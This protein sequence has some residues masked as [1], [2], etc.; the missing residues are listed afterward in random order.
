MT[1]AVEDATAMGISLAQ[2]SLLVGSHPGAAT[3]GSNGR[4]WLD[5]V[6][7]KAA[8][9]SSNVNYKYRHPCVD[10]RPPQQESFVAE[11]GRSHTD[12]AHGAIARICAKYGVSH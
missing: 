3:R 11:I 9:F 2:T 10:A 1:A 6:K 7:P 8:A 4:Q 5:A 12:N